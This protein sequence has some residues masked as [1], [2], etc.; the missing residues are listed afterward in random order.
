MSR[1]WQLRRPSTALRSDCGRGAASGGGGVELL[2][3]QAPIYLLEKTAGTADAF[4]PATVRRYDCHWTPGHLDLVVDDLDAAL[5][6]AVAAG[7]RREG[8]TRTAVW[9]RIAQC[10]DPFGHGFC[11]LQFLGRGYDAI[12]T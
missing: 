8:D 2:G 11:L 9:G 1:T 7:A 3:A 5:E 6:R 10:A 12:A 4:A